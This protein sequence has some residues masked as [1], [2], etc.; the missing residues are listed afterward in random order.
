MSLEQSSVSGLTL[1]IPF[2]RLEASQHVVT[3][4]AINPHYF[5]DSLTILLLLA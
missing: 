2:T 3:E 5:Q 4:A 1:N